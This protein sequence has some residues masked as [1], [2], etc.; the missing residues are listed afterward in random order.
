MKPYLLAAI[1]VSFF[2]APLAVHAGEAPAVLLQ[3]ECASCHALTKPENTSLDRL[4]ERK[5]P[6]L[7]YAGSKFNKDWLVKWLQDP[8]KIRPAG[9]FYRKH[10]KPGAKEDVVDE[11]S[12]TIHPKLTTKD[13]EAAADA[14]MTLTGPEGLI[15]KGAFKNQKV[16]PSMGTMYF[17][18]LRGCSACHMTAPGKGGLSGPEMATA[19]ARLQPDF[20]YSYIKDPQKIDKGIW[21][22]KLDISD[23]DLQKLTS[24][25]VQLSAKEDKK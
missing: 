4:W 5:G 7:Y 25:I 12:L 13:A 9:E 24:Y 6:D 23:A 16:V 19:G 2:T 18:K 3:L 1:S 14:L 10:V 21:M 20:I 22:P 15:E 8:T 11:P 17:N